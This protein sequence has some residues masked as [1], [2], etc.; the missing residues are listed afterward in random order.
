MAH[1]RSNGPDRADAAETLRVIE[2]AFADGAAG[3]RA[4]NDALTSSLVKQ[5]EELKRAYARNGE[6]EDANI[7]LVAVIDKLG[8]AATREKLIDSNEKIELMRIQADKDWK[9][10]LVKQ[11]GPQAK[12]ALD[13]VI[14]RFAPKLLQGDGTK[15]GDGR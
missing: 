8:L 13:F 14:N 11:L 1:P 4:A 9:S 12:T 6:L 15:D 3:L 10:D 7:K 2:K 5:G